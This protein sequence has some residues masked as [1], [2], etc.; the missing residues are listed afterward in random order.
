MEEKTTSKKGKL[1]IKKEMRPYRG[2]VL[3]LTCFSVIS[4]VL[5]LAFAYM[6]R[7]LINSASS[8]ATK[9][10]WTFSAILLG[11]LLLRIALQTVSGFCAER[12]R[13]K[14]TSELRTRMF[15]KILRSDYG[16]L[17]AY[18]SGELLNRLT[19]DVQEISVDTVG[20]LPSIVGM[21]VQC[22]GAIA[23]LATI[24]PLFT[25]I[26][27]V[28]GCIFGGITAFFR[29]QI[30][31]HQKEVLQADGESRAFM[32]EGVS[33][34]MT[35]K[36]YGAE[37][38]TTEKAGGLANVYYQKRMRRN[39]LRS[40]MNAVFSLLG[41]FGLIFAVVWCSISVLQGN[42]DYGSILSVILLLMQLQHPFSAFSSIVPVYYSRIASGERLC[43][44][45]SLP[46]ETIAKNSAVGSAVYENLQ[47]IAFE[48]VAFTYGRDSVLTGANA[49]IEKG[50]IVCLTGAS[51]A[52]KSTLF[53]L[54]LNVFTPTDGGLYLCD[55][56]GAKKPLTAESRGLFAYVPQ[57]KF[58][59]SG[60]IYEN[61]TFF[62]EEQQPQDIDERIKT[63]LKV[64]CAEFV[65]DLP[66]G[67]QT[68]LTEGGGGLSEGQ[69][70]RLAVA[71]AILSDRP[72]LLLDEATSALD[73]ETEKKLLENIRALKDKTCLIVTHRPAA[74]VIA[75][76]VL[77][78]EN[79][80]ISE[81]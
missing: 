75:D 81:K 45:E 80:K 19:S 57:G 18:H 20:L 4:T 8:G 29:K 73:G 40:T 28:C 48:N 47:R 78:V 27:V 67:L 31:K 59:F 35:L 68:P 7:Y 72:I 49:T 56:D 10:L 64:A 58:L 69:T 24:D 54:L 74:L 14:I 50:E 12:L 43:E 17:Q 41:N 1:W 66:Q 9:M 65:W 79:G 6:V 62:S 38:K 32:Q 11:L 53:K 44:I 5:S 36:A 60:T 3:F 22:L 76:R 46:C 30:K 70:Q 23:A 61:L 52:G 51:G 55:M 2:H 15:G 33:S 63:A 26:Y 39:A 42:T 16:R 37:E 13:A 21:V 25:V 34:V 71:R 77:A